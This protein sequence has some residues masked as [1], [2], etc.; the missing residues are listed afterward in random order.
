MIFP[1]G[2]RNRFGHPKDEV[3]ARHVAS[4][5]RIHRSDHDGAVR[6]LLTPQGVAVLHERAESRRYWH[7]AA[8]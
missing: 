8:P 2:Y 1:V 6:V 3:V 4:G 5:A 7:G